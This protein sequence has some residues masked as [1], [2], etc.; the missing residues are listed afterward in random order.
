MMSR[1]TITVSAGQ[2]DGKRFGVWDREER[3]IVS[4]HRTEKQA[5]AAAKKKNRAG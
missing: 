1:H 5:R 3:K 4:Y 2:R